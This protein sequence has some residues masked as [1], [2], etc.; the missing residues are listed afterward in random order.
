MR[1]GHEL[2]LDKASCQD[3][4]RD[5]SREWLGF[6]GLFML[7]DVALFFNLL[8]FS[9]LFVD[10]YSRLHDMLDCLLGYYRS[11]ISDGKVEVSCVDPSC[12]RSISSEEVL[13]IIKD[14]VPLTAKFE[15]FQRNHKAARQ[16]NTRWC[17]AP[18]C[19]TP[20][21]STVEFLA[22]RECWKTGCD[23]G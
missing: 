13:M 10:S 1:Q 2:I 8:S 22:A 3:G 23:D 17:S 15:R 11:L 20:I 18:G 4:L 9:S 12:K 19:D 14:D 16:P 6:F 7:L 5:L 21:V